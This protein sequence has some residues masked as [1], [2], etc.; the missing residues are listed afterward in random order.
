MQVADCLY[1]RGDE[2]MQIPYTNYLLDLPV[3]TTIGSRTSA[4]VSESLKN[5]ALRIYPMDESE[6]DQLVIK[7]LV[8]RNTYL[9]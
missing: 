5:S 1:G 4:V 8:L 7:A 6:T 9:S 3:A 2:L